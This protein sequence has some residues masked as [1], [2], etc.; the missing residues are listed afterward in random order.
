MPLLDRN[1]QRCYD[2]HRGTQYLTDGR[3][4]RMGKYSIGIDFGTL[5]GRAV[6]ADVATGDEVACATYAYPHGVMD[7]TL[8][9]GTPLGRDWALQDPADY[10]EVLRQ[11]VPEL[12][13][14]ARV[15]PEEIVGIGTDFTASTTIPALADGTPLSFLPQYRSQ[16][17]AWCML[18]KH[19]AAQEQ[20]DKISRLAK[21]RGEKWFLR[22]GERIS[23]EWEF[24][25][26]LQI[27]EE[28]PHIYEATEVLVEASD[29]IV[30]QLTG[31]NSRNRC[32]A[33]FKGL[34]SKEDGYPSREFFAALDP[35]MERVVEEKFSGISLNPGE[36][37]GF[38]SER[39][40]ELTGLPAG[41][42]VSAGVMDA[43]ACAPACGLDG[44]GKM[45]NII[46]TSS[47]HLVL[48]EEERCF[49]GIC[50]VADGVTI[51][52]YFCYEAGLCCVGDF[53]AW[54]VDHCLPAEYAA[55]AERSGMSKHQLLTE[56]AKKLTPGESGLLALNW[57]NGNRSVLMDSD[58]TGMI[59]GLDLQTR[60]EEIYRALI[61]STAFNTRMI[62]DAFRENGIEIHRFL[63]S[64]G[65]PGK[66]PMAM[67]IYADVLRIPVQ[68]A[69]TTQGA[70]MGAAIYGA[71]A[72]G[73][74]RG[75]YGSVHEAAKKMG[76]VQDM[77]YQ[78]DPEAAGVYD[79]L[80]EEY[81]RLYDLFGR[82]ENDVMKRLKGLKGTILQQKNN[83]KK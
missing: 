1:R 56:K 36:R 74:E 34:W 28:A 12:L 16:P 25:K 40:A 52:D 32:A 7:K 21:E 41:I 73:T 39:G 77:I 18:W 58:L 70:A 11:T 83:P 14:K 57:W 2:T 10:L 76:K 60:P 5:S 31:V 6:L 51:P 8:P 29:W 72:A 67:Q 43:H 81:R 45:L 47:V 30:W 79:L 48:R 53:F 68:L 50:G 22:Y 9:D 27:L 61:E 49:P 82:G 78:P 17:H 66:N 42:P 71:A 75:G 38:L 37:A 63:A 13:R 26:L 15:S 4:S 55:E 19:H 3:K 44:P 20:A 62:L 33:G 23:S 80:Y 35:R 59:L 65:I 54:F 69:G 64:G 24:P 46:G